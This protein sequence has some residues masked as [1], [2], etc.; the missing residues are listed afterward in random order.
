[1]HRLSPKQK[2]KRI[3]EAAIHEFAAQGFNSANVNT[4]AEMAEVSVGTLY[5]YFYSK[6]DLFLSIIEIGQGLLSD[7]LN[8]LK[9]YLDYDKTVFDVFQKLFRDT[10]DFSKEYT[11]LCLIYLELSTEQFSETAQAYA[12]GL[13]LEFR[14]FYEDMLHRGIMKGEIKDSID[15][16]LTSLLIDDIV[17]MLQFSHSS[18]YHKER[19]K[20][21]LGA[22]ALENPDDLSVSLAKHLKNIIGR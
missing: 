15:I 14:K 3:I 20:L 13:E 1:M 6:Q 4:I 10:I 17:L 12:G 2:R 8:G 9:E 7:V 21:Y 18:T 22:E 19:T 16:P 11:D 5:N